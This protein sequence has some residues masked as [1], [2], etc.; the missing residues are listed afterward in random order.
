MANKELLYGSQSLAP[1]DKVLYVE[2]SP[3]VYA[4]ASAP[5]LPSGEILRVVSDDNGLYYTR[6]GQGIARWVNNYIAG[7]VGPQL[8]VAPPI[9]VGE[10]GIYY[11]LQPDTRVF[12]S[13]MFFGVLTINDD[14]HFEVGWC[15][16]VNGTGTFT[17]LIPRRYILTGAAIAG[18]SDRSDDFLPSI[19]LLNYSDGVR[20]ITVRIDPND[21][22]CAI[23]VGWRGWWEP[24]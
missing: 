2:V 8:V 17:P 24:E 19:G 14:C 20:S 12:I 9:S 5:I 18:F 16:G 11:N 15:D 22:T 23:V 10:P 21:V 3:G 4:L 1:D 13:Q 7:A 6:L